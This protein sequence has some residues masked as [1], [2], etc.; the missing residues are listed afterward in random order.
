MVEVDLAPALQTVDPD[1]GG[2]ADF[3]MYDAKRRQLLVADLKFGTGV[4]V[5]AGENPQL[6]QYALGAL[7]TTGAPAKTVRSVIVQP[8]LED[9]DARISSHVFPALDLLDFA[10][11]CAAAAKATREKDPVAVP[12]AEQCK[13]CPAAKGNCDV[14]IKTKR[15]KPAGARATVDDFAV[16]DGT[17]SKS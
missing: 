15:T 3:I 10:A 1:M 7:L 6:K 11:D 16:I 14:A 17:A 4:T 12:G 5:A 2:T 9:P 8:R 13:W